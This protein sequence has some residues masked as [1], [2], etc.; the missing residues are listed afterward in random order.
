VR[1]DLVKTGGEICL[2]MGDNRDEYVPGVREK[3]HVV[4]Q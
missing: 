3:I 2:L 1:L 4:G